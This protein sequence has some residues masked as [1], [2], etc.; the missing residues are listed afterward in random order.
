[1]APKAPRPALL[2]ALVTA[3]IAMGSGS[4]DVYLPSLPSIARDLAAEPGQVQL[5]LG[6]FVLGY[7]FANLVYGPVADRFGRRPALLWGLTLYLAASLACVFADS[8]GQLIAL[9][10]VQALG[11]CAGPVVGRATVR[12]LYGTQGAARMYSYIGMA[13]TLSPVLAPIVGGFL[14][15]HFGW[16]SNFVFMTGYGA[17]VLGATGLLLHETNPTPDRTAT[18]P[19]RVVRNYAQLLG[20]AEFMGY[21]LTWAGTFA[22]IFAFVAGSSFVLIGIAHLA[23]ETY[24]FV[25]ASVS[26]SFGVGSFGSARLGARWGIDGTIARGL[27]ALRGRRGRDERVDPLGRGQRLDDRRADDDLRHR[28]GVRPA[29]L[30]G[31]RHRALPAHGGH[32]RGAHRL[33]PDGGGGLRRRDPQRV[34]PRQRVADVAHPAG[35]GRGDVGG[36]RAGDAAPPP[37][38]AQRPARRR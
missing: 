14:E 5:T 12:D 35:L 3:M 20:E 21:A 13:L 11:A 8:I 30:P 17:L 34:R 26:I 31:G 2:V 10:F 24:G 29:Q 6:V 19:R 4:M 38:R 22:G 7:S 27:C 1:M 33:L 36:V 23:P 16:R 15:A 37:A 25:F 9:R 28:H 32:G 18:R